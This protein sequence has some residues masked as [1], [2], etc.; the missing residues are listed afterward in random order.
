MSKV[1]GE[2]ERMQLSVKHFEHQ[3]MFSIALGDETDKEIR[4]NLLM[5]LGV[6]APGTLEG[7]SF[8][9]MNFYGYLNGAMIVREEA[10]TSYSNYNRVTKVQNRDAIQLRDAAIALNYINIVII[11]NRWMGLDDNSGMVAD[12][13]PESD[14]HQWCNQNNLEF[15]IPILDKNGF[16]TVDDMRHITK[17]DLQKMGINNQDQQTKILK[18]CAL[19]TKIV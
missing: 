11:C 17:D 3:G 9:N 8:S 10:E 6:T 16:D 1:I 2:N 12:R 7:Y 5:H 4:Q 15:L 18:T 19:L 13:K 14:V